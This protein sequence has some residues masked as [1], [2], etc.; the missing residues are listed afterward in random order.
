MYI[1][2]ST[3]YLQ[4]HAHGP[5]RGGSPEHLEQF[6]VAGLLLTGERGECEGGGEGG[7]ERESGEDLP[8]PVLYTTGDLGDMLLEHNKLLG[9]LHQFTSGNTS[10]PT[11]R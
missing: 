7:G 4:R 3:L 6:P 9:R 10:T 8:L 11:T 2:S 5:R 1:L